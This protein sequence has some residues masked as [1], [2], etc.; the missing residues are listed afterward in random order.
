M[1]HSTV[2]RLCRFDAC[3]LSDTSDK[4]GIAACVTGLLALLTARKIAGTSRGR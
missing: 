4:L 1:E 2:A 3:A